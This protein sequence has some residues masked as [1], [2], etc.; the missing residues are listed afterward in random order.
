[1]ALFALLLPTLTAQTLPDGDTLVKQQQAAIKNHRSLKYEAEMNI[2]M[3]GPMATKMTGQISMAMQNPGKMRMESKV[4]GVSI[5]MVSDGE[6]TWA[7]NSM[8][9]QYV[10]QN[11]AMGPEGIV[12]MMGIQGM[13]DMSKVTMTSKTLRDEPIEM[14]G[15][16]HDCWVVE[17]KVGKMELP[18]AA[19]AEVSDMVMTT[20]IDKK[21]GI[22][23]QAATSMKMRIPGAADAMGMN[24]KL[25]KKSLKVDEPLPD[26][27]FAFTPPAGATETATL[28][29]STLPKGDLAGKD[30]A[31]FD[32]RALDAKP[33]SLAALKGQP[34]LLD[35]WATW[36]GPCRKSLPLVDKMYQDYK[37]Q[38]L[39]VLGV[40]AGEDRATV[41]EFLHKNPIAY[42]VVLGGDGDILKSYEVS[43][44]PTFVMIGRDGRIVAH[45][46]GFGGE[47]ALRDMAKKAGLTEPAPKK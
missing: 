40:D 37:D 32:V 16:K 43:A 1:L 15:E 45:Q 8:S 31:A 18:Q 27:L 35:F 26:S 7:Y 9:N 6:T 4:A 2:E 22:D 23:L 28:M 21:T 12:K 11:A 44:F 29:G 34:V 46:I 13:P 3:T 33:Y 39:V 25:V 30:A 47:A 10:K 24:Q 17:T 20:W 41:E 36:C 19:G 14:D 42:P 5:T 38:G